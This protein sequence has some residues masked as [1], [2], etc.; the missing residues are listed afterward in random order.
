MIFENHQMPENNKLNQTR[1]HILI[2]V[3]DAL[4]FVLSPLSV[5]A[6]PNSEECITYHIKQK[7]KLR[8]KEVN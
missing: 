7:W 3:G 5:P 2:N 4:L 6:P 8:L 1:I